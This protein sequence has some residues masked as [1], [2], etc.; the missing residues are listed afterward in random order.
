[1]KTKTIFCTTLILTSSQVLACSMA[2]FSANYNLMNKNQK[3]IGSTHRSLTLK[4]GGTY[5]LQSKSEINTRFLKDTVTLISHGH[6]N[7]NGFQPKE[8][9]MIEKAKGKRK[10]TTIQPS[11]YDIPS[12]VLQMRFDLQ[13][14]KKDFSYTVNNGKTTQTYRFKPLA[15]QVV[16]TPMGNITVVPMQSNAVAGISTEVLYDPQHHFRLVGTKQY[17]NGH[18]KLMSLITSY[19]AP[20]AKHCLMQFSAHG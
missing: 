14:G 8:S 9:L 16:N 3:T 18:L 5:S 6:F 2:N 1:M 7:K 10:L 15:K 13:R 4:N 11:T 19:Q 20:T 12:Y 17:K